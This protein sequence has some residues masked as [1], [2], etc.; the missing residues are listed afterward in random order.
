MEIRA[1]LVIGSNGA[2]TL[3]GSSRGLSS[4]S[5]RSRFHEIRSWCDAILIGGQTSR[6]EP[7]ART[8]VP[9]FVWSTKTELTGSAAENPVARS[10]SKPLGALLA[11]IRDGGVQ[12]LLCEGGPL[13]ISALLESNQLE[14][15]YLTRTDRTGDGNFLNFDQIA[16]D[17]REES[18]TETDGEIFSFL[19]KN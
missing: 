1:N 19:V 9:L 15:L 16:N 6:T 7:Y 11:D 12:R 17:F 3:G 13:L 2:M 4:T 18:R 5:D 8:P 14:S 10:S